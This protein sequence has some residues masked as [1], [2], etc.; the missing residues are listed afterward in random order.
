MHEHFIWVKMSDVDLISQ[1]CINDYER[2]LVNL[3]ALKMADAQVTVSAYLK[4]QWI[5][6]VQTHFR[7]N[8]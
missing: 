2:V 8:N 7:Q 6:M 1:T 3:Q 4:Y 5:D